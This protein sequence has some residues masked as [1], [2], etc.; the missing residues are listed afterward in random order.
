LAETPIAE[1]DFGQFG[2]GSSAARNTE[3]RIVLNDLMSDFEN[4]FHAPHVAE[5]CPAIKPGGVVVPS[6]GE[7]APKA[8]DK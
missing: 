7:R 1:L 6:R 2:T 8:G 4:E 5:G 3:H